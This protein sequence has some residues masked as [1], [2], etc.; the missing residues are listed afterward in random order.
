MDC[1]VVSF[2]LVSC[3]CQSDGCW[4]AV[5]SWTALGCHGNCGYDYE[6]YHDWLVQLEERT[7]STRR[8]DLYPD[9]A[10]MVNDERRERER[11]YMPI[12]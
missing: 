2:S 6:G 5:G 10:V 11:G 8:A 7:W 4:R 3:S 12:W 1:V 9:L